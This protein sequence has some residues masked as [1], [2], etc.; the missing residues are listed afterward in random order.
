MRTKASIKSHSIHQMLIPFPIGFLIG[1]IIFDTLGVI[2]NSEALIITGGYMIIA[3]I[4]GGLAAAVPGIIDF[5]YSVPPKS[6]GH[7]RAFK[8]MI[9]NFSAV[10]IFLIAII[11]RGSPSGSPLILPLLLQYAGGVLI[12]IGGWMGGTMVNRNFFGPEHRYAHKGR[13]NE[14]S[15]D[16]GSGKIKAASK[17]ELKIDQMKLLRINGNR[18]VLARTESGY[19][20]FHDR[21]THRGSSL[22]DGVMICGTVQC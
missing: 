22:A 11:L 19:T 4:I 21:C 18:V 15:F 13:W 5:I 14:E 7:Q 8:H 6:T 10:T 9:V 12:T 3:G 16:T 1:S 17:D 2:L 20:A